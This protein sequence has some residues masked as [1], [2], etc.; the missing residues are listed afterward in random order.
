MATATRGSQGFISNPSKGTVT[1]NWPAGTTAGDWCIAEFDE[2]RPSPPGAGWQTIGNGNI[3]AKQITAADVAA[4]S[5]QIKT[6]LYGLVVVS[7][8]G[9]IGRSGWGNGIKLDPGSALFSV[10]WSDPYD[11]S[12]VLGSPAGQIGSLVEDYTHTWSSM[13]IRHGLN[14][15]STTVYFQSTANP[16]NAYSVE[17]RAAAAPPA[18]LL[19]APAAGAQVNAASPVPLSWSHQGT[20]TQEAYR[21]SVRAVG[22]GTWSYLDSTGALVGTVQTITTSVQTATITA[23]LTSG[24]AYEW[25]VSTSEAG[26]GFSAYSSTRQFT[27]VAAPTVNTVTPS[28]PAERLIGTVSW[29]ATAGLGSL[30]AWQVAVTTSAA[31][32]P[33][34]PMWISPATAGTS[35]TTGIPVLDWT[36]GA[37]YKVWVR[38]QQSG[39]LW[40]NWTSGAF[41]VSWTPPAAPSGIFGYDSTPMECVVTGIPSGLDLEVQ[42]AS[43]GGEWLPLAVLQAPGTVA[44]V[45]HPLA[46]YKV[47]VTY[48]A[49]SLTTV[50]GVGLGSAWAVSGPEECTDR[51]SYFVSD[52]GKDWLEVSVAEDGPVALVQGVQ[53]TYGFG[54]TGARVDKG[55]V[56]GTSG[57]LTLAVDTREERDALVEWV[58]TRDAWVHRPHPEENDDGVRDVPRIRMCALPASI[59]RI[60]QLA[61]E[62]R[63]IKFEWVE[64]P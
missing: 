30:A 7:G 28:M 54:S 56:Q 29:T 45:P 11:P 52:D 41:T 57:S 62:K 19:T 8:A 15:G 3:Y 10:G 25:Q 13:C 46:P 64:R 60:A 23:A 21:V 58:T 31:A 42:W 12:S 26:L 43:D 39:G 48:R 34:A 6:A 16:P 61:I 18:P 59:N 22:S 20:G 47:A 1:V 24:Q 35:T 44:S 17:I 14:T 32:S 36:N 63:R 49:R 5:F 40:S 51:A 38:V 33:D 2:C 4:G 55:E 9:G 37:S 27:P 53:V 50:D